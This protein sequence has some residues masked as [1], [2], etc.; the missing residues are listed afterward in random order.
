MFFPEKKKEKIW[1]PILCFHALLFF[2]PLQKKKTQKNFREPAKTFVFSESLCCCA[3]FDFFFLIVLP[4]PGL[5]VSCFFQ[6]FSQNFHFFRGQETK[7]WKNRVTMSLLKFVVFC[8]NFSKWNYVFFSDR[9]KNRK[10]GCEIC[11]LNLQ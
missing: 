10:S 11:G 9:G 2:L 1:A 6:T 4:C 8:Q 7:H 5:I 3:N